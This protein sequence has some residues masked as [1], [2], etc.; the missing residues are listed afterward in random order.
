M[1]RLPPL[2]EMQRARLAR[3]ATYDG[4]F[5]VAVRTRMI[6]CRPSCPA[7]TPLEKNVIY[8]ATPSEALREC[9]RACKRCRPADCDG[10][11]PVWVRELLAWSKRQG[12]RRL[13][14]ADLREAGFDPVRAR[15]YFRS[16][17]GMTFLEHA[18]ARR[19]GQALGR[20]QRGGRI[21]QTAFDEGYE[22][23]SG[24]THAFSR[25]FGATPGGSKMLTRIVVTTVESPVGP[26]QLGATDRGVCL[27]EFT[28][29]RGL[30]RELETLT[31]R[32]QSPI[33]PG[34]NEHVEQLAD[35]L[36]RYFAGEL[37]RFETPLDLTGTP[38]QLKVWNEL[39]NIPYGQTISY[40]QLAERIGRP[41]AQRAVGR[42]NGDNRIAIVIPCHRVVQSDG[43][44][45]G[46]GGGLWRKQFLL[47]LEA[48]AGKHGIQA[49]RLAFA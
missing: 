35:E 49:S 8:Y 28:D 19:M 21:L 48:A 26:L 3:D 30:P 33:A 9:Y 7:R 12:A 10:R 47:D 17:F 38:F 24:F 18:R 13:T 15:R 20:L 6:F 37:T 4:V 14:D 40:G 11:P 39:L 27:L 45:R 31:K 5:Y 44:L 46:Y 1:K 25:H 2:S 43:K 34:S 41:G 42:A 23:V 29:R 16:H 32:F 22:S 36:R